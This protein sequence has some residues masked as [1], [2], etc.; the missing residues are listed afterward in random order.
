MRIAHYEIEETK[1]N[2]GQN[3]RIVTIRIDDKRN[4]IYVY[5]AFNPKIIHSTVYY[6]AK[7]KGFRMTPEKWKKIFARVAFLLA[8]GA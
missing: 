8:K 6:E 4:T 1:N 5:W 2:L 7:H 3:V